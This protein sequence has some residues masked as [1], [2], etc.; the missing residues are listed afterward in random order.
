MSLFRPSVD[1][2]T[3][4]QG[5]VNLPFTY[6]ALALGQL[7]TL[8]KAVNMRPKWYQFPTLESGQ[9]VPQIGARKQYE[10]QIRVTPGSW[11]YGYKA[12]GAFSFNITEQATGR[13]YAFDYRL[14]QDAVA[15][16]LGALAT[17][18]YQFTLI[19]EPWVILNPALVNVELYDTTATVT[20]QELVLYFAEP[21]CAVQREMT[22][23]SL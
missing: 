17:V 10:R 2:F 4:D 21:V 15:A 22:P 3:L 1:G 12:F 11:L 16:Q 7:E 23:C 14:S 20:T 13:K 6:P 19:G 9:T 18:R 5:F 8:R